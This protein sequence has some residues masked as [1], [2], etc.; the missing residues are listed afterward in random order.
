M[1][2]AVTVLSVVLIV[3]SKLF[4]KD[5]ILTFQA[6]VRLTTKNNQ[7]NLSKALHN[8]RQAKSH[9]KILIL[10]KELSWILLLQ[11]FARV[12]IS[13]ILIKA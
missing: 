7:Q 10:K 3:K 5:I 1:H 2:N 13:I 6:V 4:S 12:L 9:F 8:S 11:T